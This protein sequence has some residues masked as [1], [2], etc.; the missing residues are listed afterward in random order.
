[1]CKRVVSAVTLLAFVVYSFCGSGCTTVTRIP[2]EEV[3]MAAQK[4]VTRLKTKDGAISAWSDQ[5]VEY[6]LSSDKL[7]GA[8]PDGS[9][10]AVQTDRIDSVYF[11]TGT[12][13]REKSMP[14]KEFKSD[15]DQ[16]RLGQLR[17]VIRGIS[18]SS[19]EYEF[20]KC[21]G[22]I[23]SL[24]HTIIG[25]VQVIDTLYI[26]FSEIKTLKVSEFSP[27][28]TALFGIGIALIGLSVAFALSVGDY[29]H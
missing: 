1:M 4:K 18:T 12:D 3:S 29:G 11:V 22:K 9:H 8:F 21:H 7:R 20:R 2:I 23:D 17:G 16:R 28:K 14:Y 5:G 13:P 26:P 25:R 15:E 6:D 10:R 24:N 27:A 19:K